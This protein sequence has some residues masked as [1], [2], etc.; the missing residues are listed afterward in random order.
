M[1]FAEARDTGKKSNAMQKVTAGSIHTSAK[2]KLS[3]FRSRK[4][5]TEAIDNKTFA[6]SSQV[7][8]LSK[9]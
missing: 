3:M 2:R 7:S 5:S 6:S 9:P 4:N 1:S 8:Q